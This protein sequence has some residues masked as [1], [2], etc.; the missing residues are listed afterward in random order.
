MKNMIAITQNE[1]IKIYKQWSFRI[2]LIIFAVVIAAAPF[3]SLVA[4]R[5][6]NL[7]YYYDESDSIPQYLEQ[8]ENYKANGLYV[9]AAETKGYA[10]AMQ[11]FRDRELAPGSAEYMTFFNSYNYALMTEYVCEMLPLSDL[12]TV[13]S[14]YYRSMIIG[15]YNRTFGTPELPESESK[16]PESDGGSDWPDYVYEDLRDTYGEYVKLIDAEK[17]AQMLKTAQDERKQCESNVEN[18]NVSSVYKSLAAEEVASREIW[19]ERIEENK[20]QLAVTSSAIDKAPLNHE[21]RYYG[22]RVESSEKVSEALAILEKREAE[23]GGWEYKTYEMMRNAA[24]YCDQYVID[25]ECAYHPDQHFNMSYSEYVKSQTEGYEGLRLVMAEGL[26]SIEHNIPLN[27][28]CGSDARA[29][30]ED[31]LGFAGTVILVIL[32]VMAGSIFASEYSSG[33][34]RLLLIRPQSRA[35]VCASKILAVLL[36]GLALA[37]GSLV[38]L[39]IED[40]LLFGFGNIGTNCIYVYSGKIHEIGFALRIVIVMLQD[41]ISLLPLIMFSFLLSIL[42]KR[43]PLAIACTIIW[44]FAVS[45]IQTLCALLD[46]AGVTF[47]KYTVLPYLKLSFFRSDP[48]RRYFEN[49]N[50]IDLIDLFGGNVTQDY[51]TRSLPWL[52]TLQLVLLTGVITYFCFFA[53]RRQQIKN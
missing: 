30:L 31:H 49:Y 5:A 10:D 52:G 1:L 14:D 21:I 27:G 11:Y 50:I 7:I 8:Y 28:S 6:Q 19:N 47:L 37:L 17:Y 48:S 20:K 35:K 15:L 24:Y 18:F 3:V 53:F 32:A 42:S 38:I 22:M 39:I 41:M 44:N 13:D 16:A 2:L 45:S 36:S 33:T 25:D 40:G 34:I 29:K 51:V 12:S 43:S 26:Y 46:S 23:Y 4:D 9:Y